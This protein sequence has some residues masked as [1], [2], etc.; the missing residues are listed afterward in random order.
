MT[1]ASHIAPAPF[2]SPRKPARALLCA[3]ACAVAALGTQGCKGPAKGPPA[4]DTFAGSGVEVV[5]WSLADVPSD[6]ATNAPGARMPAPRSEA[7][8]AGGVD[9]L[10][11][12]LTEAL[13][14]LR[15]S[16]LAGDVLAPQGT[17]QAWE[18]SGLR[19]VR[20]RASEAAALGER[21][22]AQAGQRRSWVLFGNQPSELVRGPRAGSNALVSTDS[23]PLDVSGGMLMLSMRAW[24]LPA[25]PPGVVTAGTA[26][27]QTTANGPVPTSEHAPTSAQAQLELLL[28][29]PR[30]PGRER[31]AIA[32]QQA[33]DAQASTTAMDAV[34]APGLAGVLPR[35]TLS[36]VLAQGDCLLIEP[37]ASGASDGASAGAGP[38]V[39]AL[40]SLGDALLSDALAF[41]RSGVRIAVLLRPVL[42]QQ[43]QP[44][45]VQ[46]ANAQ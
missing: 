5:L 2:Q 40:P 6:V 7:G 34:P 46:R 12:S 36:A 4:A 16:A 42:T 35:L 11:Q 17:L 41:P 45:R 15:A 39:P 38:P 19:I 3:L 23:G 8:A 13:A 30:A 20:L 28:S 18:G 32:A 26:A 9:P 31:A 10:P 21:F 14:Q 24:P 25:L 37:I 1:S 44:A 33:S 29:L 27:G 22:G 43:S